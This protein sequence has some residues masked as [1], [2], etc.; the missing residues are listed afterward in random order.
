MIGEIAKCDLE[1]VA[2]GGYSGHANE[3][4]IVLEEVGELSCVDANVHCDYCLKFKF[5]LC[6][7]HIFN[8]QLAFSSA[9]KSSRFY[10]YDT[11]TMFYGFPS[12]L[13]PLVTTSIPQSFVA[14]FAAFISFFSL[15]TS[16]IRAANSPVF[17][18]F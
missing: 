11:F 7:Q 1:L 5:N 4:L 3:E 2:D 6:W 13:L 18:F 8:H 12:S 9:I 16:P 10:Y 14:C 17:F 15:S